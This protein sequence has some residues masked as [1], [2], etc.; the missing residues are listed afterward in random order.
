MTLSVQGDVSV[1]SV[2]MQESW[3]AYAPD[4][5]ELEENCEYIELEDEFDVRAL[6][7]I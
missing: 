7:L 2:N 5:K 6:S 4:F 1:W 3:S